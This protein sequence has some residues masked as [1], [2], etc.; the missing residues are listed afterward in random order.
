MRQLTPVAR[1][2]F[3]KPDEAGDDAAAI[4]AAIAIALIALAGSVLTTI[5]TVFGGPAL[6]ARREAR[7]ALETYREPL[8]EAAYELQGRL[9]NILCQRFIETFVADKKKA[10]KREAALTTTLYVFAQYLGWRE[11]IR[12]E[13]HYLRYA[14]N[15]QTREISGLVDEIEETFLKDNFGRQFMLWRVEQRGLGERMI[16]AAN[17]KPT[18]IGY[19][20]FLEERAEMAEWLEPL[21]RDL[22]HLQDGG[23]E[24]LKELQHHLLNLVKKLDESGRYPPD[25]QYACPEN[26]ASSAPASDS[27]G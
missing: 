3:D 22:T 27:T 17:G 20:T 23:R 26:G 7:R 16:T 10:E 21:E 9:Y 14:R 25:L 18:C 19:A 13:V 6:Q 11:V 5:L 1:A 4:D 8:L 2:P 15:E 24:R 12:R